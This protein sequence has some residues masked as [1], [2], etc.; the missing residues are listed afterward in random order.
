MLL[1]QNRTTLDVS[2]LVVQ[3]NGDEFSVTTTTGQTINF[4]TL[5]YT[6]YE[7]MIVFDNTSQYNDL[8]YDPTTGSRQSR[9]KLSAF[10]STQWDGQLNAQGFIL[11]Q[12]KKQ[13]EPTFNNKDGP[14]GLK[15]IITHPS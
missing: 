2:T 4:L 1:D 9:L 12:D 15:L 10:T 6:N 11:N 5:K 14:F 3:R 8:I 7:D 13:K